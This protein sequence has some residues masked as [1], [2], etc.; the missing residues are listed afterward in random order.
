MH[1]RKACIID[2]SNVNADMRDEM[3]L[4]RRRLLCLRL[5]KRHLRVRLAKRHLRGVLLA[6]RRLSV[7][8]AKRHLRVRLATRHLRGCCWPNG[9]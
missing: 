4:A 5:A 8:L 2:T 3:S 1:N 6:N 9:V 7:R